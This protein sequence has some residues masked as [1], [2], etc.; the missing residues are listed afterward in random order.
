MTL[1][2]STSP[3][4]DWSRDDRKNHIGKYPEVSSLELKPVGPHLE[5]EHFVGS[6]KKRVVESPQYKDDK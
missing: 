5:D 2:A 1:H 3:P 6:T 4:E